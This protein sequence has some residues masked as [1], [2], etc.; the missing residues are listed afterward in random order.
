MFGNQ[1]SKSTKAEMLVFCTGLE[2]FT[3]NRTDITYTTYVLVQVLQVV[4]SDGNK[5]RA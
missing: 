1:Y 4:M 3:T 5:L 2:D